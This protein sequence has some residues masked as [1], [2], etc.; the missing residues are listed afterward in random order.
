MRQ[1]EEKINEIPIKRI[2]PDPNQPREYFDDKGIEDLANSI[3][4]LG[5]LEP[6]LVRPIDGRKH[7]YMIVH[8]E[9]RFRA[10]QR[11]DK[12]KVQCK[13]K[14]L[15]ETK[16]RD[17]QLHENIQRDNLSDIELALE[18]KRRVDKAQSHEEIAEKIGKDRTF[19]TKRLSLL[20]LSKKDQE[21]LLKGEL[22]YS[23]ARELVQLNEEEKN[24]IK[25]K[26]GEN[27]TAREV[28][29]FKKDNVPRDTSL[30][31]IEE[32]PEEG[33]NVPRDTSET[34]NRVGLKVWELI[35]GKS[36]IPINPLISALEEDLEM[37]NNGQFMLS[38]ETEG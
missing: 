19:V 20:K 33:D 26:V 22:S 3:K 34:V 36:T 4:K 16:A 29:E 23:T 31:T 11:L 14:D 27:P 28:Q 7:E 24:Q 5:L 9:R 38:K 18:F 35:K 37:L 2:T 13:V 15:S 6:I 32:Y 25:K 1:D 21:R 10:C 30:D 17:T 8:G 12:G